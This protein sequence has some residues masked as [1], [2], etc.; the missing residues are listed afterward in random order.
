MPITLGVT[1]K[2]EPLSPVQQRTPG[3]EQGPAQAEW[4]HELWR[5]G[6][7][8]EPRRASLTRT[9]C[10]PEPPAHLAWLLLSSGEPGVGCMHI[11]A[12]RHIS[13]GTLELLFGG[14]IP[15]PVTP[16]SL[17]PTTPLS[18]P[19]PLSLPVRLVGLMGAVE[20]PG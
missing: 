8:P 18:H 13:D 11:C 9:R 2:L 17:S 4:C 1:M 12:A 14:A 15:M 5:C 20:R 7:K 10:P 16:G 6:E 3:R 19:R